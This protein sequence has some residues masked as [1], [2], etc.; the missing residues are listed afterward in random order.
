MGVCLKLSNNRLKVSNRC[1]VLFRDTILTMLK[2]RPCFY[3]ESLQKLK[4]FVLKTI[5][6]FNF[7]S[8]ALSIKNKFCDVNLV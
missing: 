4:S 1:F 7:Y 2:N 5:C 6:I 3:N 8:I